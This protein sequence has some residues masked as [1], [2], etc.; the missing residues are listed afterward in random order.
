MSFGSSA[1]P[2][3]INLLYNNNYQIVQ[4][5][6]EVAILVEMVHDVRTVR[7]GAQHGPA[8]IKTWMG[9]SVGRWEGDTL[10]I[11]TANLR[12]PFRGGSDNMK[13]VERLTR[14]GPN[15]LNYQ[16]TIED[17]NTWAQPWGGESSFV[18]TQGPIYEYACHEGNHALEGILAGARQEEEAAKAKGAA[19]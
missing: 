3:M 17:A 4:T 12:N 14:V 13:V 9:D 11:E 16:F 8:N 10:V 2:P 6:D 19:Q 7:I 18:A 5:K 15:E 1:G